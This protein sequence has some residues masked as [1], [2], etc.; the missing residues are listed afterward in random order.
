LLRIASVDGCEV[1]TSINEFPG[2]STD[3][4]SESADTVVVTGGDETIVA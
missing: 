3:S 1:V 4:S 2:G